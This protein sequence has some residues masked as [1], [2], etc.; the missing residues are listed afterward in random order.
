MEN[1]YYPATFD[2]CIH[3]MEYEM[4]NWFYKGVNGEDIFTWKDNPER[5]TYPIWTPLI[6]NLEDNTTFVD[7]RTSFN[8]FCFHV[9]NGTARIKYLDK[10][11]IE[12]LFNPLDI[13]DFKKTETG[14]LLFD[15][16]GNDKRH[17]T[18]TTFCYVYTRTKWL[19]IYTKET[20]ETRFAGFIKNK[21]ELKKLLKQLDIL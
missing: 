5:E 15:I 6:L 20:E 18:R 7:H 19:L 3:L 8:R 12:S 10:E 16:L 4:C 14:S 21:L 13:I 17:N 9:E 1:K 2:E 11:D